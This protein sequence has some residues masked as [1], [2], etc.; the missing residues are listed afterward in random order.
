MQW[1]KPCRVEQQIKLFGAPDDLINRTHS[2]LIK[3]KHDVTG[4]HIRANASLNAI[5]QSYT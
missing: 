5:A 1:N 2:T 4:M 3:R